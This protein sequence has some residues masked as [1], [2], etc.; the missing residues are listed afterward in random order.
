MEA[1]AVLLLVVVAAAAARAARSRRDRR[2]GRSTTE[3]SLFLPNAAWRDAPPTLMRDAEM[4]RS[5]D[6]GNGRYPTLAHI[7][8][9]LG[10]EGPRFAACVDAARLERMARDLADE[11]WGETVW[12]TGLVPP[13]AFRRVCAALERERLAIETA[14]ARDTVPAA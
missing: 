7:D 14:M 3:P 9:T 4:G 2:D 11:Y 5:W 1:I 10:D 6:S 12:L 13:A 8:R